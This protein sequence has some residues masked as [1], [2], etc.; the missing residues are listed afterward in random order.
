M[1]L[2]SIDLQVSLMEGIHSVGEI[3]HCI[4]NILNLGC[5]VSWEGTY[6]LK[7]SW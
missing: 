6:V 7:W 1:F 4:M 3:S 5:P 2:S